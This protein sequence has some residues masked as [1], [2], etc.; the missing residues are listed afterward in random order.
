[1]DLSNGRNQRMSTAEIKEI[2]IQTLKINF[3]G[4]EIT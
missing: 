2:E 3:T 1:M 4:I